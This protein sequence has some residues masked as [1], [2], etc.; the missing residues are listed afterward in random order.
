MYASL[1]AYLESSD[2]Y[3][4]YFQGFVG[5]V[6]TQKLLQDKEDLGHF[7]RLILNFTEYHHRD[8]YFVSKIKKIFIFFQEEIKQTMSNH[9]LFQIFSKSKLILL[10]LFDEKIIVLDRITVCPEKVFSFFKKKMGI[11]PV[12]PVSR[13]L[14]YKYDENGTRYCHFFYPEIQQFVNQKAL[15]NIKNEML[16]IDENI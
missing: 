2:D 7:L 5:I 1:I 3:D 8:D 6:K 10:I 4:L 15:K 9:E 12:T 14:L 16:S 11:E 13:Y